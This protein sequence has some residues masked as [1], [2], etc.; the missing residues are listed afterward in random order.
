MMGFANYN[1]V[2]CVTYINVFTIICICIPFSGMSYKGGTVLFV[3]VPIILQCTQFGQRTLIEC[4][5]RTKPRLK[6]TRTRN[7][8]RALFVRVR[9][10]DNNIGVPTKNVQTTPFTDK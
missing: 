9:N 2:A 5:G 10:T 4:G 7:K 3:R 8:N 1:P 6:N